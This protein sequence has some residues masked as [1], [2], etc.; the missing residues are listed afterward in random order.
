MSAQSHL[1]P[2]TQTTPV[3]RPRGARLARFVDALPSL[4]VPLTL[5]SVARLLIVSVAVVSR[6]L[7]P[8]AARFFGPESWPVLLFKHWDANY[9]LGI[10]A[11][12]YQGPTS[13]TDWIA[14]FPGTPLADRAVARFLGGMHPPPVIIDASGMIVATAASAVCAVLIWR[15]ARERYGSLAGTVAVAGLVFG[16]YAM[17]LVA[18]YSE[19]LYLAFALCAW[20]AAMRRHWIVA[21]AFGA[22]ASATRVNGAFLAIALAVQ[23]A[24]TLHQEGRPWFR[25]AL[26]FAGAAMSGM[27]VYFVYLFAATGNPLAWQA[28]EHHGWHRSTNWPWVSFWNTLTRIWDP[29]ITRAENFQ[30]AMDLLFA[31]ITVFGGILLV[32]RRE[33]AAVTLVGLT[34]VSMMTSTNYMSMARGVLL[35]FPFWIELGGLVRGR[36]RWSVPIVLLLGLALLLV[37]THNF[38]LGVWSG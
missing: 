16:P 30:S 24:I 18:P 28:A 26:A 33:W 21:A 7:G 34:A 8:N 22:A 37:N 19:S 6:A 15:I 12:G 17:T 11:E 25:R 36:F 27:I 2:R 3:V 29:T 38:V 35:L 32:R 14:F 20:F 1:A 13:N 23:F 31:G 9:Y 10:A 4:T 5:W